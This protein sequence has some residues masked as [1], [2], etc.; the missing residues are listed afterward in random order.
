[1]QDGANALGV[2]DAEEGIE[3]TLK[4][5]KNARGTMER[6]TA[7][8]NLCAG[9]L[10]LEDLDKALYYCNEALQLNDRNWRVYNNRALI[11]VLQRRFEEAEADLARCDDLHPHAQPTKVVRQLLAHAREPVA[12]VITVDD[13]R[14]LPQVDL[15]ETSPPGD[16]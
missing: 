16:E 9:Y 7:L 10:M 15:F 14:S 8:S 3:L 12:P 1:L 11:Y 2:G 4:G 6:R 13:R 5:L